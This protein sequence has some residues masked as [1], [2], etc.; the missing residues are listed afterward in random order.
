MKSFASARITDNS[1]VPEE[2]AARSPRVTGPKSRRLSFSNVVLLLILLLGGLSLPAAVHAGEPEHAGH[3]PGERLPV[4]AIAPFAV[5]LLSIAIFP[6]AAPH[7]WEHNRNKGIVAAILAG[8][9]TL[10]GE[11]MLQPLRECAQELLRES[12]ADVPAI[13]NST[14]GEYSGAL[15]AAALAVHEWKPRTVAA[16]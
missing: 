7:W 9:L 2:S 4:L 10:L 8:P 12:G 16:A 6:L 13:V 14:M 15:G 5:L 1:S 3:K 11:I